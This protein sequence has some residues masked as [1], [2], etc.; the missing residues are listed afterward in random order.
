VR[1]MTAREFLSGI[2][3]FEHPFRWECVRKLFMFHWDAMFCYVV[4][5]RYYRRLWDLFGLGSAHGHS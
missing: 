3:F 5:H 2:N 4:P 1:I